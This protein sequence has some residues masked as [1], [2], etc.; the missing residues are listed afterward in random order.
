MFLL[1]NKERK[2][3]I[4]NKLGMGA[5][6]FVY[7]VKCLD[8]DKFYTLKFF[9][10]S[11][12]PKI[13][14][15]HKSIQKNTE[16][17]IARPITEV[18]GQKIEG[19]VLPIDMVTNITGKPGF[20]YITEYIDVSK[21]STIYKSWNKIEYRPDAKQT[22]EICIKIAEILEGVHKTGRA[23]REI[24]EGNVYFDI[25]SGNVYYIDCDNILSDIT[26]NSQIID[27]PYTAPEINE[28]L[29]FNSETDRYSMAVYF[30][31]LMVGGYPYEGKK[32]TRYIIDNNLDNISLEHSKKIYDHAPVF[33]F[34]EKDDSN[35][36]ENVT[37]PKI[38]D[39]IKEQWELQA[40]FW[41][42]LPESVK[43]T[44]RKAF[45]DKRSSN[46][47]FRPT[48]AKWIRVLGDVLKN[49]IVKCEC[50]RHNYLDN[51]TCLFC[52]K[53]LK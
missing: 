27:I 28:N 45:E 41:N 32:S 47:T 31:R 1:S 38:Y 30:Y 48:G 21:Y 24:N 44:F 17:L 53:K 36:I 34:D 40:K 4:L 49:G 9:S 11:E 14:E 8:D 29:S 16:N 46:A 23:C 20:G 37:D 12:I 51:E 15:V 39:K 35:G 10:E 7:K 18:F 26:F 2:Y 25:E 22:C 3:E 42:R 19:L 43:A 33:V 5:I 50:G 13:Q 6:S 52:G